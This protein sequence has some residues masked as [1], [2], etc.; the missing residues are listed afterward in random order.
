MNYYRIEDL[1]LPT[2]YWLPHAASGNRIVGSGAPLFTPLGSALPR[3]ILWDGTGSVLDLRGPQGTDMFHWSDPKSINSAGDIVGR[4]APYRYPFIGSWQ[5]FVR[6]AD[7]STS[8][9]GS[10]LNGRESV[11][12][13]I[14]DYGLAVGAMVSDGDFRL[15][16]F[17]T[18]NG[19][20]V[21]YDKRVDGLVSISINNDGDIAG[22]GRGYRVFLIRKGQYTDLGEGSGKIRITDDGLIILGGSIYD[23]A[24]PQLGWQVRFDF[25]CMDLNE[26]GVAV[27][28]VSQDQGPNLP[29][30]FRAV[31][32]SDA[33]GSRNLA[34]L[35]VGHLPQFPGTSGWQL[36]SALGINAAG[37][38][39][40]QGLVQKGGGGPPQI[41]VYR[42][43]PIPVAQR[44]L[45][46]RLYPFPL[47]PW[48]WDDWPHPEWSGQLSLDPLVAFSQAELHRETI[49]GVTLSRLAR[50]LGSDQTRR[51]IEN[52][53]LD[54][55]TRAVERLR[56]GHDKR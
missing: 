9:L 16:S 22:I 37:Q 51:E 54:A 46:P 42:A 19:T 1:S 23:I 25:T 8:Y 29:T 4:W 26:S 36:E 56:L 30:L 53:A 20:V 55:I 12:N 15:F 27:G 52:A 48:P 45:P 38:I 17:D 2:S 40:G 32:W 10:L 50:E 14:N 7:G 21:D 3:A 33:D 34:A 44:G 41:S 47:L 13:D 35:A 39:V 5:A 11:L 28:R 18:K 49:H 6:K 31:V 43:T 24:R